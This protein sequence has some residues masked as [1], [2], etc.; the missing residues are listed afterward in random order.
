VS[1]GATWANGDFNAD[2]SVDI[3]DFT[4]LKTNWLKA[5]TP[6]VPALSEEVVAL[7]SVSPAPEPSSLIMLATLVALAGAWSIGRRTAVTA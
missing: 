2:G 3:R 7:G 5:W 1:S 6:A 4:L